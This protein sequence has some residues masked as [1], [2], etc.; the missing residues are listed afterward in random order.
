MSKSSE[1]IIFSSSLILALLGSL[2][3]FICFRNHRDASNRESFNCPVYSCEIPDSKC[4]SAPFRCIANDT[5][6]SGCSGDNKVCMIYDL[7]N[8]LTYQASPSSS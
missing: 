7:T 5:A 2:F 6:S 4:G 1:Y 8:D 3:V